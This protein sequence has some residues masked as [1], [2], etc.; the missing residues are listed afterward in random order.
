MVKVPPTSSNHKLSLS[1]KE[2]ISIPTF[3]P[4]AGDLNGVRLMA[5]I[6]KKVQL[7]QQELEKLKM[8]INQATGATS[9]TPEADKE[10]G[11]RMIPFT[12]IEMKFLKDQIER[13]D[14]AK[15]ITEEQLAII[16]IVKA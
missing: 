15:K 6:R 12:D 5:D 1:V 4:E 11:K 3:F 9:W 8:K 10:V 2:R 7:T 16:E 14:K 13:L